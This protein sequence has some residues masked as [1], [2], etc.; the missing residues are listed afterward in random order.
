MRFIARIRRAIGLRIAGLKNTAMSI[1]ANFRSWFEPTNVFARLQ[2]ETLATSET[3]F[4]AI[5]K[6]SNSMGSLP[7]DLFDRDFKRQAT[8]SSDLLAY[9]LN[10]NMHRFELLR[11]LEAL[12]NSAGNAYGPLEYDDQYQVKAIRLVDPGRVIPVIEAKSRELWY[13]IDADTGTYWVH[14]LDM[15]HV[16]HISTVDM[17]GVSYTG[18][19]PLSVLAKTIDFDR[20]VKEFSLDQIEGAVH[21]SFI[22]K[23]AAML[24]EGKKKAVLDS[25][26][27]FYADNGG[28]LLEE[29][30][31]TITPIVDKA[32]MDTK[33]FEVEKI[34]KARVNEVF[35]LPVHDT[36]DSYNT[37]EQA[38]LEYVQDTMVPIVAQY[39]AEFDRKLLTPA[40]RRAGLHFKF[41]MSELLRADTA[42]LGDFLMKMVRTG[43]MSPDQG[44]NKLGL[45]SFPGGDVHV[46]SKDLA[47]VG[48]TPALPPVPPVKN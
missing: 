18:I 36:A 41:D 21:A 4:A 26:K 11:T 44:A 42:T 6:L 46:M 40:E 45:P 1:P 33:V 34:T 15:V 28:V 7:V 12:R 30:G 3:V 13:Q 29:Q 31:T 25:F 17:L 35:G 14:N 2:G 37:R 38:A 24:D 39:E 8:P 10:P 16:K 43:I 32:I 47:P 48:S 19:S 9:G 5:S 20:K 23:M 27:A 22:L